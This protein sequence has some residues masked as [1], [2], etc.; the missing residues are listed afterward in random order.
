MTTSFTATPTR[1]ARLEIRVLLVT[2]WVAVEGGVERYVAWLR[3]AL[4]EVGDEVELLTSSAGS[5]AAESAGFIARGS[6]RPASQSVLQIANPFAVAVA[7]RAVRDFAPDV[8]HVWMFEM[9]LSPAIFAPFRHL[10]TVLTVTN[11]K[12]VCPTGLK[13]LPDGRLCSSPPGLVCYRA[14]CVGPAHWLRDRPRYALIDRAVRSADAILAPSEWMAGVLRQHGLPARVLRLGV[15]PVASAF[16]RAPDG[17][18]TFLYVGRLS[19]EKGVDVLLRAFAQVLAV[20]PSATL[21]LAGD[22]PEQRA[23]EA[24]AGELGLA[25]AVSFVGRVYESELDRELA[26]AWAL[27]APSRWGESFGLIVVEALVRG[28]PVI[29]TSSGAF[30][31]TV[32]VGRDGVLVANGSIGELAVAL[33][34]VAERKTFPDLELDPQWVAGLRE[35][36]AL[37][38][39]VAALRE[40]YEAVIA[41]RRAGRPPSRSPRQAALPRQ[42]RR[43]PARARSRGE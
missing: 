22:G 5:A 36:W 9:H 7:R 4:A 24:L 1:S 18:P 28:V 34:S 8:V 30:P 38:S 15:P 42:A 27:V 33:C 37:S 35:R 14:G 13:L 39:H 43:R 23:L 41:A 6:R 12:P 3:T 26:S 17:E 10:P 21:R 11:Y 29:A 19:R 32:T 16:R 25:G 31:E 20:V 2:D 40:W